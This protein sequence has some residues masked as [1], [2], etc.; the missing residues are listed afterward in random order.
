M[1]ILA[2]EHYYS[3]AP[4]SARAYRCD[5]V[6]GALWKEST[7]VRYDTVDKRYSCTQICSGVGA[8][9]EYLF[10]AG[11]LVILI[12]AVPPALL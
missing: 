11:A 4:R 7:L 10:P 3:G 12:R 8:A 9:Y 1:T 2:G 6:G 5:V